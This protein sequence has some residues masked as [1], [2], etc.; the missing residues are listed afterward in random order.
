VLPV[1]EQV[2]FDRV[3]AAEEDF[4]LLLPVELAAFVSLRFDETVRDFDPR[5]PRM[6]A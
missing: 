5:S 3:G 2:D 6:A 4:T 1:A